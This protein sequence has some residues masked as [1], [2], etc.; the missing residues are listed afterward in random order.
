MKVRVGEHDDGATLWLTT[1]SVED[2]L[3]LRKLL[4]QVGRRDLVDAE[5]P[6]PSPTV[7]IVQPVICVVPR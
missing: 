3:L 7:T 2:Q 6:P 5:Y 1:E 4:T